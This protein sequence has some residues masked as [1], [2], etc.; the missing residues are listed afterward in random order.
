MCPHTKDIYDLV[1][2][3]DFIDQTMML[4]NSPG[5]PALKVARKFFVGW[6]MTK[7]ILDENI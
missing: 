2:L 1:F 5:V 6:R 3:D 4:V 7:W